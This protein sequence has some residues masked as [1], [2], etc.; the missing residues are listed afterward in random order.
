M[1]GEEEGTPASAPRGL[2][3][4]DRWR[5]DRALEEVRAWERIHQGSE[6]AFVGTG[7]AVASLVLVVASDTLAR[8]YQS[9]QASSNRW[10]VPFALVLLITSILQGL[11]STRHRKRNHDWKVQLYRLDYD[12]TAKT[13]GEKTH[14]ADDRKSLDGLR[15]QRKELAQWLEAKKHDRWVWGQYIS[16]LAGIVIYSVAVA[17]LL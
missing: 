8:L 2:G 1:E 10:L 5:L 12:I 14:E 16:L 17:L 13:L 7:I 9:P 6:A 11:L 3:E 4:E 15:N